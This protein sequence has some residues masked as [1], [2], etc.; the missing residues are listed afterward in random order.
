MV[1]LKKW[2]FCRRGGVKT[3]SLLKISG[4]TPDKIFKLLGILL[5]PKSKMGISVLNKAGL[6]NPNLWHHIPPQTKVGV[7]IALSNYCY[8]PPK[9]LTFFRSGNVFLSFFIIIFLVIFSEKNG[10]VHFWAGERF[11]NSFAEVLKNGH[12][13]EAVMCFYLFSLSFFCNF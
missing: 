7:F 5:T 1:F 9:K 2:V 3:P 10:F 6:S 13:S 4:E 12:F 8:R 11:V